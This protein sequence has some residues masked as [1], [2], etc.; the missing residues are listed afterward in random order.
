[1]SGDYSRESFA[2]FKDYSGVLMQQGRVQLDADW[3]ELIDIID[4]R[5]RAGTLDTIGLATVPKQTP[6]GF[7][8]LTA[9]IATIGPG[10]IYV[11]GLL[12]ENH[13]K[14]HPDP[15]N[16]GTSHFEFDRVLAELRGTDPVPY[17]E[18]PYFPNV[19]TVAPF[20]KTGGPHLVYLDVWRREVTYLED[21]GLVE[22]AVGVDTT[23][24]TQ[25][26]WQVRVLPNVGAGATCDTPDNALAGWLDVIKPSAGRLS[27]AAVGVPSDEDPCLTPPTGGFKGLE[28]RLY[29]VEIHDKGPHGTATFK[30][31]RDEASIATAVTG[32]PNLHN[33][34]VARVGRDA[35]LRFSA[36]DWIEVTDDWR[37]FAGLPGIMAR[38]DD[39][40]DAT[41]TITLASDL[42]AGTFPVNA[43]HETDPARHT[44]IRRWDQKGQ[45][46]DTSNN[47]FVDLDASG[48]AGVIPVPV[49]GT[50]ITLEDGVQ[51][52]FTT[53]PVG[54]DYRTGDYWTFAARTVDA[55]VEI[56]QEAP[57]RGI[58][59]HYCRLAIVT[60]PANV[61]DCRTLWPPDFGEVGCDCTVCLTPEGGGAAIQAA[62]DS[63]KGVGA[64]ICLGPG[65]YN[66]GQQ[67]LHISGAQALRIKG[68][69]WK[70][71]LVY[72][73]PG[74]AIVIENSLE[75]TLEHLGILTSGALATSGSA[76][77]ARNCAGLSIEK[78]VLFQLG[79]AETAQPAIGLM[80]IMAGVTIRENV[81]LAAVGIGNVAT[82]SGDLGAPG[83]RPLLTLG[84][85]VQDNLLLCRARGISLAGMTIHLSET[86]L[87]GNFIAQCTQAGIG[88]LG[89]TAGGAGLEIASNHVQTAGDGI[90]AGSD[91][92]HVA[93]N[94]VTST[95]R[96]QGDGIV[97]RT[98][99]GKS[100][101]RCQIVNN[102][103][104]RVGGRG[105][106]I[107]CNVR[108]ALIK[109]N[110][111]EDTGAGIV[112]ADE[113]SAN[114]L[115][116]VDNQLLNVAPGVNDETQEII[117]IR[118]VRAARP[119]VVGNSVV[120]LGLA[121]VQNPSRVGIQ[122]VGPSSSARI[123]ANHVV[124]IGPVG[125]FVKEGI[126]I[127]YSGPFDRLEVA[128]NHVRRSES[129]PEA[130]SSSF[131]QALRIAGPTPNVRHVALSQNIHFL[132]TPGLTF[133]LLGAKIVRLPTGPGNCIVQGNQLDS[134]GRAETAQIF[135]PG[136]CSFINN[137]CV[138]LAPS[139]LPVARIGAG[140]IV[141]GSNVVQGP[142]DV[143]LALTVPAAAAAVAFTVL[144]NITRGVIQVN[145]GNLAAP[146]V[147]LNVVGI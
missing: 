131:W 90:I 52:T 4:R 85:L 51:I 12:A 31:S 17:D 124:E 73:G 108:A 65:L 99:I 129:S 142:S 111:L 109:E 139:G 56:L 80:G 47:L 50:S 113:A 55:S 95:L 97:L 98:G 38:I 19:S 127:D 3:N 76:V 43:Q 63:L 28:N 40:N 14:A 39:V 23:T 53:A 87:T 126:G 103:V 145:G 71:Q 9:G 6:D 91:G 86:R 92:A 104:T 120:G 60:L 69:G 16:P 110:V 10:R 75:M 146:W 33:L 119:A 74:P 96:S 27:T 35:F 41:G 15:A 133:A 138:L 115:D 48:S 78:C 66:L 135:T 116:V 72:L 8:I 123:S 114:A 118:L 128:S 21:P 26:V 42:P 137:Q 36:G 81:V 117:G 84:L 105:I 101:D 77:V 93:A 30:W 112:M 46:T 122:L 37:E 54:G 140:A 125:Q 61:T 88:A 49:D 134:Y 68:H 22:K 20:P 79:P 130:G 29:R 44:R 141:A 147:P 82:F 34:T 32:I 70:T 136:A 7:K 5:I 83:L 64:T 45:V 107:E 143:A 94:F 89:L 106:S 102:R 57:P 18:Q 59:H 13:G 121:A 2:P 132:V 144:G 62:I 100:I 25:T 1:M 24:R 11:D 67:P 58:H